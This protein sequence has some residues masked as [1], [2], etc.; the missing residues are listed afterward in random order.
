MRQA[1]GRKKS[2]RSLAFS[3]EIALSRVEQEQK[4]KEE[5]LNHFFLQT[6]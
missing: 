3:G 2:K 1:K 5:V 4:K 6:K